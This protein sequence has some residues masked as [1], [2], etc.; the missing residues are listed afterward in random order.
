MLGYIETGT[1]TKYEY[2]QIRRRV[3]LGPS[4]WPRRDVPGDGGGGRGVEGGEAT[5]R[6]AIPKEAKVGE[7]CRQKVIA[8]SMLSNLSHSNKYCM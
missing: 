7:N 4:R 3:V 8:M 2:F 1:T 6:Q 5:S